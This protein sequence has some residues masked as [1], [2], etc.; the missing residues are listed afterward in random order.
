MKD[1]N[2]IIIIIVEK[3]LKKFRSKKKSLYPK[4][5]NHKGNNAKCVFFICVNL[6]TYGNLDEI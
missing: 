3:M 5:K 2:G 4:Y 1:I 6:G